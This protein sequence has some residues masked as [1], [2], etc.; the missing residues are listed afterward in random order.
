MPKGVFMMLFEYDFK[1][2]GNKDGDG[3]FIGI[4]SF[5]FTLQNNQPKLFWSEAG[6]Y[7]AYN[8]MFVGIWKKYKSDKYLDCIFSFNTSGTHTKLPFRDNFYKA[9]KDEDECKCYFE[10]KDE[11][12][13]YGWQNYID[14]DSYK[15]DWWKPAAAAD[16]D[17]PRL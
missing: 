16:L 14:S 17:T 6:N 8:N 4:G 3:Q 9:F 15:D 13:Q 11:F 12:R 5:V 7:R 1:E 10:I 2:P